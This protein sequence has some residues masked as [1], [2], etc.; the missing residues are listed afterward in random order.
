MGIRWKNPLVWLP[1]KPTTG[2]SQQCR[3]LWGS[4]SLSEHVDSSANCRWV[5]FSLLIKWLSKF[6]MTTIYCNFLPVCWLWGR[7][8]RRGG[9]KKGGRGG[10]PWKCSHRI[11][12]EQSKPREVLH[13]SHGDTPPHTCTVPGSLILVAEE[14][15][16]QLSN[17]S[18]VF[19][20]V[21]LSPENGNGTMVH[22]PNVC[23]VYMN[24]L[25]DN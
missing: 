20:T 25:Q 1:A 16:L 15:V 4:P 11:T 23:S 18:A 6:G 13:S 10:T 14:G 7:P 17:Q 5:K 12:K 3:P 8:L 24:S 22:S 9:K 2:S 19:N 21:M